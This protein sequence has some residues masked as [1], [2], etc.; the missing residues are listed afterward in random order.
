MLGQPREHCANSPFWMMSSQSQQILALAFM[1]L[2][3]LILSLLHH[4]LLCCYTLLALLFLLLF[5]LIEVHVQRL[6]RQQRKLDLDFS[7]LCSET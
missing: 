2:L 5:A 3:F 1:I 7:E 6:I 4:R